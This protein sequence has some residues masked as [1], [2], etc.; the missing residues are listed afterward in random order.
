MGTIF[1]NMKK[2][3]ILAAAASVVSL[4]TNAIAHEAT[5]VEGKEKCYGVA[6]AGNNDCGS[7]L[8]KHGCAGYSKKDGSAVDFIQVPKGLCEKLNGGLLEEKKTDE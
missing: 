8:G 4:G 1:M 6:K 3:F 2:T 7:K 5:A